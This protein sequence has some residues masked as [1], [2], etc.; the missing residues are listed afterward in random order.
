[1]GAT[2]RIPEEA[3]YVEPSKLPRGPNGYPLCRKCGTETPSKRNT[4]CS[5]ACVHEWKL[6]TQ[7]AY[8]ARHVLER[9]K[10]VCESCGT[11]C[12][13]VVVNLYALLDVDRCARWGV[14]KGARMP[15]DFVHGFEVAAGFF[16]FACDAMRLP[17]HLR[18]LRRR[19]WEMDHRIPVAEGGGSCGLENLRTLCWACH[20]RATKELAAR[21]AERRRSEKASATE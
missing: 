5:D 4:F 20:R 2:S 11:D 1:M 18:F 19:L 21:R 17:E 15:Q 13:G 9:D 10:G 16:G 3:G 8:Q 12:E 7:P 6:R 14:A